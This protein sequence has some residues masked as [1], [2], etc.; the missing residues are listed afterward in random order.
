MSGIRRPRVPQTKMSQTMYPRENHRVFMHVEVAWVVSCVN[1]LEYAHRGAPCHNIYTTSTPNLDT[2]HDTDLDTNLRTNVR[3]TLRISLGTDNVGV[4]E[5]TVA[6]ITVGPI[7]IDMIDI[8]RHLVVA[9][10][11]LG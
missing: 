11:S 6:T 2:D 4:G 3:I 1:A 7:V 5:G 9:A 10:V 8:V